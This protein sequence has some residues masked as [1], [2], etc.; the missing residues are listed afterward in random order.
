VSN[1]LKPKSRV[2]GARPAMSDA[3][4]D[5]YRT[6][7]APPAYRQFKRCQAIRDSYPDGV[8]LSPEDRK[9]VLATLRHHPRGREKFGCGVAHVVVDTYVGGTRCFFVIRADGSVEDFSLRKCVG[10]DTPPRSERLRTMMARFDF[11]GVLRRARLQL[12][13]QRC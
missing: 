6:G 13:G 10:Y 5:H 1:V 11:G 4:R 8:P 9:V 3:G 12:R 2:E 7:I